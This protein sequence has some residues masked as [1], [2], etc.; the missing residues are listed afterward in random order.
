ML[1]GWGVSLI[2][3]EFFR[4]FFAS[5]IDK[6]LLKFYSA[7]GAIPNVASDSEKNFSI[8]SSLADYETPPTARPQPPAPLIQE[9]FARSRDIFPFFTNAFIWLVVSIKCLRR[10]GIWCVGSIVVLVVWEILGLGWIVV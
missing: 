6:A 2:T 4:H 10:R 3:A 9:D 5:Y 7:A 8:S 1:A